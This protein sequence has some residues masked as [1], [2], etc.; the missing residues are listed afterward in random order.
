[1]HPKELRARIN[2]IKIAN[3]THEPINVQH[4]TKEQIAKAIYY[5]TNSLYGSKQPTK[6]ERS[7]KGLNGQYIQFI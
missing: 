7:N 1:M 5:N 2:S 3:D 6:L 4:F